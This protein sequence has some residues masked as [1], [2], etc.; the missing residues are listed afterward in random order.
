[1][2]QTPAEMLADLRRAEEVIA[3]LDLEGLSKE[4]VPKLSEVHEAMIQKKRD[5]LEVLA[6]AVMGASTKPFITSGEGPYF[7][8]IVEE[9]RH[10][11]TSNNRREYQSTE[12]LVEGKYYWRVCDKLLKLIEEKIKGIEEA[13]EKMPETD[14]LLRAL[15]ER[16]EA[17]VA[18]STAS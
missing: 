1:M 17:V 18:N 3:R 10:E 2:D 14:D 8:I 13:A 9:G 16:L 15:T 6:T 11:F 7:T 5:W 12:E 4:F